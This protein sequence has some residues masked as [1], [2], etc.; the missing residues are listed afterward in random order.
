MNNKGPTELDTF[1]PKDGSNLKDGALSA[2]WVAIK[3][4]YR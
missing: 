1:L 2:K 3:R 4:T